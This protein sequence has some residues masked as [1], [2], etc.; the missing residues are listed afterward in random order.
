MISFIKKTSLLLIAIF[1][2]CFIA[3]SNVDCLAASKTGKWKNPNSNAWIAGTLNCSA[4]VE[5]TKEGRTYVTTAPGYWNLNDLDGVPIAQG[6]S[7]VTLEFT[8]GKG[9]GDSDQS[10]TA[11][12]RPIISNKGMLEIESAEIKEIKIY[13]L[14]GR[15]IFSPTD[16]DMVVDKQMLP[17]GHYIMRMVSKEGK[18]T[19]INFMIVDDSFFIGE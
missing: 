5:V 1:C 10:D 12:T 7:S 9:G 4:Y 16:S 13:D 3:M 14:S 2:F 19:T 18:G 8:E 6:E 11:R 17:N 15:F